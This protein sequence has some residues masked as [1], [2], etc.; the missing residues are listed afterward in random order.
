[1]L[2]VALLFTSTTQSLFSQTPTEDYRQNNEKLSTMLQLMK[3][4]YVDTIRLEKYVEKAIVE[5]LKDLDPHST[6][7]SKEEVQRTNEPLLGNFEGVGIQFQIIKD[8]IVVA[9]VINGG[10]S[11]KVGIMAGDKFLKVDTATATGKEIN[12]KWVF[13]RLR[14]AKDT[15]VNLT[16]LRRG[17]SKPLQFRVIRDKIPI[18]SIDVYFMVSSDVGY[19]KLDR[20]AQ[21]TMDEFKT[22]LSDLKIKG[23]K[24]LVLDLRGNSGGYLNTAIQLSDEFLEKNKLIVYTE[25]ANVPKQPYNSTEKGSFQ[26]GRLVVLI[27]EGSASASEIVSGA[28]QDWDRGIIMGRRSF[29]KG[30]VQKPYNL[31]DGSIIRFTTSRYYTPTGRSIQKPYNDGVEEYYKDL[32]RRRD[33][34]EFF[35]ADSIKFPD[36]LQYKTPAGRIVYGGGGIMPDIFIPIDTNRTSLFYAKL[37]R[38]GLFN[39]YTMN[40]LDQKRNELKA[41]YPT[42]DDFRLNFKVD[43]KMMEDFMAFAAKES[44]VDSLEFDFVAEMK[45][46]MEQNKDSINSLYTSVDFVNP[47]KIQEHIGVMFTEH[48]KNQVVQYMK[49]RDN[50]ETEKYIGYQIKTLLARNLYGITSGLQIW[51]EVDDMYNQAIETIK[52]EKLFKKMKVQHN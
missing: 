15:E 5:M 6:Y 26:K 27:D 23:M 11:E 40:I 46:F 35:N 36:S 2:V 1:I 52:D 48:V 49:A 17:Q 16:I 44:V 10:P 28:I 7:I 14:G 4:A 34:N 9:A 3:F 13:D 8:T 33:H 19:I 21:T 50:F 25:G 24:H 12:N 32:S 42:S 43:S 31:N 22:A 38:A 18:N 39:L 47:E 20:F 45:N 29:G 30:L 41:Q 51:F 37:A